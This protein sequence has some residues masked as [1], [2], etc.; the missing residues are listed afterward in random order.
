[1]SRKEVKG[2]CMLKCEQQLGPC[3]VGAGLSMHLG[4]DGGEYAVWGRGQGGSGLSLGMFENLLTLQAIYKSQTHIFEAKVKEPFL[5]SWTYKRDLD[6]LSW[7]VAATGLNQFNLLKLKYKPWNT[8]FTIKEQK[9]YEA[10]L[11]ASRS[12]S[13]AGFKQKLSGEV[14]TSPSL[15]GKAVLSGRGWSAKLALALRGGGPRLSV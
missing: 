7:Q 10:S 15:S 3:F 14:G 9:G 6:H 11:K 2:S 1:M 12:C 5:L 8:E 4:K 13:W